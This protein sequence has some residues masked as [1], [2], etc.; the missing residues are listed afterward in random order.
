MLENT[1]KLKTETET[2]SQIKEIVSADPKGQDLVKAAIVDAIATLYTK[3]MREEPS[4]LLVEEAAFAISPKQEYKKFMRSLT[5]KRGPYTVT[6]QY[7]SWVGLSEG[8]YAIEGCDKL[9][10][11]SWC[12]KKTEIS[13]LTILSVLLA[14]SSLAQSGLL[15]VLLLG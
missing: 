1:V 8:V 7:K 12:K 14:I 11:V 9:V 15:L 2:L 4:L 10:P 6:K 5:G 13:K 3:T